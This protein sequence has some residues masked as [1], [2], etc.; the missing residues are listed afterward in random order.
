MINFHFSKKGKCVVCPKFNTI[1]FR[2]NNLKLYWDLSAFGCVS[3]SKNVEHN[4]QIKFE[5]IWIQNKFVLYPISFSVGKK[6]YFNC[7]LFET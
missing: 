5:K 7:R 3:L 1:L 6:V 4:C 2:V